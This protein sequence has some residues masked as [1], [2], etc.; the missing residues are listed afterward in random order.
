MLF[1]RFIAGRYL[2][3]KKKIQFI[4]IITFI[5]IVGVAIGVAALIAVLSV[6][7]GFN[8][9]QTKAL[10][11]FDPHLR[12][13]PQ[14]DNKL[15]DYNLLISK[16]KDES[17]ITGI[18]PF[19]MNKGVISSKRDNIVVFLKGVDDKKIAEVSNVKDE[20]SIGDFVF[21]D[22][23][24]FGGIILGQTLA[25][26]LMARVLDTLTVMST[27]GME[28][29]LT[30]IV[31]PKSLK[32]VV[33]GIFDANNRDY[34]KYYAFISIR[35]AQQLFDLGSSVNGV[36]IRLNNINNS[37]S[38]KQKIQPVVGQ[39]FAVS[40]WYDLHSDLY[41]VMNLE[42]WVA[43]VIL[44]LI[45]AVATFNI[46]GSLTM[47]VIEKKRDI[48]ILKTMGSTNGS[49]I[50]IFMF[51]GILI[52]IYGTISGCL[53]GLAVCLLQIKYKLFALD[54]TVY[55]ID[56]LPIDMR[57][58]DFVFVGLAAMILSFLAS[59]YPALRAAKQE[60]IKAIR[61]E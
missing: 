8:Q 37:E 21:K 56:A 58:T 48:G 9:Y 34:D 24:N 36:E 26:K 15:V 22:N 6:F 7:N 13:E 49:I 43:Y 1:E 59:L 40:T 39:E 42:R 4:T 31:T 3:S 10:T 35:Y 33:R 53:L 28:Q 20:T 18:A 54:V 51:E 16:V 30:Q 52:G 12:I 11:G 29:A 27:S 19:T 5:S 14:G 50:K 60:P 45:I 61:W 32:F 2:L 23:E 57:W 55:S 38:F 17:E 41:S 44:S 46:L 47:T 25:A